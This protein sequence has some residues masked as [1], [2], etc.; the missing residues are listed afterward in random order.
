[1]EMR[2]LGR[3][4][5]RVSSLCLGAMMFGGRTTPQ[6][7]AAIID[8]AIDAGINFID[9]ANVYNAGKSEEATGA[10]LKRNGKRDRI[11]LATKVWNRMGDGPNDWGLSR[12]HIIEQCE[13]SLRR[14]G[15]DYIDLY[16][17]HRPMPEIPIDETLRALDDL[18]RAGKIRYIGTSTFAAWQVVESLWAAKEL[19]LNRFVCEQPP[20]N[21]LDRRIEREL[22]PMAQTHGIGIIPWSPLA[23]GM[24]T[25]KYS[26]NAP[27][28]ADSRIAAAQDNPR[29]AAIY[30]ARYTDPALDAIDAFRPLAEAKG[31]PLSQFALAWVEQQ[32][33]VTSAIIG[34][35][36]M[37]QLE[38]NLKA[39]DLTITAEDRAAIDAIVPPGDMVSP[40]YEAPFGPHPHRW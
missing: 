37:E 13:A 28:P 15:T 1:M 11:I 14:L 6:D 40:Y 23:G 17:M 5:V 25:G 20:Y 19:G 24:L 34:P 3:T 10:A 27:P 30:K 12:R 7:S 38:D 16:Q 26:K 18:V 32:P 36:T 31:V 39:S 35:R 4:G 29:M 21:L 8:R 9:T 22:I 33:G 2:S